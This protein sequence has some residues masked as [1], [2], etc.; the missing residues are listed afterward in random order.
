VIVD[1]GANIGLTSIWFASKFPDARI[2]AIEPERSNYELLVRNVE[3]FPNVTT[4][5][6]A[7]WCHSGTLVVE[8]PNDKG[9]QAFQTRETA[10]SSESVERVR[11]LTVTELMSEHDLERVD[12]LKVDIEGAEKEVFG[13]ADAWI[14]SV[15][16]IAVELHDRFKVGCSR[17]FYEA[18][19][20]FPLE[21]NRG[22]IVFVAR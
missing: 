21:E 8:D 19:T 13:S 5:H 15:G 11:C 14:G 7:L 18:V 16:A 17:S 12:L 9:A 4:I 6:A 2:I 20:A 22:E 3:P 10:D 1:G